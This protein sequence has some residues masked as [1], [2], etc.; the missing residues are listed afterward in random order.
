MGPGGRRHV[1]RAQQGQFELTGDEAAAVLAVQP[2]ALR[3]RLSRARAALRGFVR[4]TCGL[5]SP[6]AP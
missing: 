6:E 5:V 4:S 2:A 1:D 3:K